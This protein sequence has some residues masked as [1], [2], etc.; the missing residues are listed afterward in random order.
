MQLNVKTENAI[1]NIST[2]YRKNLN[3]VR[4]PFFVA[5]CYGISKIDNKLIK[6]ILI[7][8]IIYVMF[9]NKK[10]HTFPIKLFVYILVNTEYL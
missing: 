5:M 3:I 6:F 4:P 9:K 1:I 8:G 10:K 2:K 7:F